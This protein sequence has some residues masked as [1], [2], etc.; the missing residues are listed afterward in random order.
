[1][2]FPCTGGLCHHMSVCDVYVLYVFHLC[3]FF[4]VTIFFLSF[5]WYHMFF[6]FLCGF[7]FQSLNIFPDCHSVYP[8]TSPFVKMMPFF[9]YCHVLTF[10]MWIPLFHSSV[11]VLNFL[12]PFHCLFSPARSPDILRKCCFMCLALFLIWK[13]LGRGDPVFFSCVPLLNL[14]LFSWLQTL[15]SLPSH[16][17]Q[18]SL[19]PFHPPW[20]FLFPLLPLSFL[21]CMGP[22]FTVCKLRSLLILSRLFL[23][24][25]HGTPS[26]DLFSGLATSVFLVHF[27]S[28]CYIRIVWEKKLW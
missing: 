18:V 20:L 16:S 24:L 25:Q 15:H 27:L 19:G 1:M 28:I 22:A 8:W 11:V 10:N 26:L 3:S 4:L 7:V 21:L 14:W 17:I 23:I 13:P 9:Y 6:S 12:S 5:S 2:N